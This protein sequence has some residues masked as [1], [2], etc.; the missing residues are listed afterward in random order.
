MNSKNQ[1]TAVEVVRSI[2]V[3]EIIR[4]TN[5]RNCSHTECEKEKLKIS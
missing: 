2:Y 5:E 3:K 1:L 4:D